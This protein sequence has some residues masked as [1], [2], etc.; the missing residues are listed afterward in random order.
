MTVF[1]LAVTVFLASLLALQYQQS[2]SSRR[3][4]PSPTLTFMTAH[5]PF[6]PQC[7]LPS[8]P[9]A[10]LTL[11]TACPSLPHYTL[12]LTLKTTFPLGPSHSLCHHTLP[13][14]LPSYLPASL[15]SDTTGQALHSILPLLA[16]LF[17]TR[18]CLYN[19]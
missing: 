15:T 7:T 5:F 19:V 8:L 12:P 13:L 1:N 10:F 9:N 18:S 2:C 14:S 17:S 4:S 11:H 3:S 6:S 16:L